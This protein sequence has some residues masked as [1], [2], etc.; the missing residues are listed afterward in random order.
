MQTLTVIKQ[1]RDADDLDGLEALV[2]EYLNWD[3][4]QLSALS[5]ITIG[6][7]RGTCLN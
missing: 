4:E 6:V 7:V 2:R 1:A 5:G 3:I